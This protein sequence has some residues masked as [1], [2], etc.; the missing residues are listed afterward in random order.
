MLL[1]G[2]ML[3][4]VALAL[5]APATAS[6]AS[7]PGA[8]TGGAVSVTPST[9]TLNGRV[10]PNNA[11]TTYFFQIGTT[12]LYGA[13]TAATPAGSGRHGMAV[14]VPVG[15]LAPATTYHYRLVAQNRFGLT[16][17]ADRTFRTRPQPL[18]VTLAANP[19]PTCPNCSTTLGGQLTG[20][21]NANRDVVLQSNPFPYM[22]GFL[23]HPNAQVTDAAGNFAFPVL[24]MPVTTQF[25]VVMAQRPEV[26]SPIVV[27]GAALRVRTAKRKVARHRHSVGVRFRGSVS[28]RND[29]GRVSI[30]K[31]RA[32]NWVEVAH[33][34]ARN[35]RSSK[36]RYRKRVRVYRSGQFRVV[37]E[38]EGAYV[39]GAGRTVR[40]RVRR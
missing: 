8:R 27:V 19:N 4:A 39:S 3:I 16:K 40:V 17:G 12:S 23:N 29:G 7:K 32:G 1:R 20:T 14:S 9:A 25:R 38:A 37:A 30:Q 13:D 15:G 34:T 28:P 24:S 26:A 31:L 5:L 22:Q 2:T 33:T 6:A 10:D 18:G 35:W 36:S 11:E 21:N